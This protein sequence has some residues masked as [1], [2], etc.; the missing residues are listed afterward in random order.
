MKSDKIELSIIVP[1]YN[2]EEYLEECLDSILGQFFSF[3]YEVI[4]VNDGSTDNSKV[5]ANDFCQRYPNIFIYYEQINQGLSVARNSGFSLANGQYIL[6]LDSDD[7]LSNDGLKKLLEIATTKNLDVAIG[8]FI[9]FYENG[10]EDVNKSLVEC[11][12]VTG[13]EW[14][15][16][17]LKKR[18]YMPAVWYKLYRRE[19]LVD[20]DLHFVPQLINEDQLYSVQV[21]AKAK[22]VSAT[23]IPFYRYRHRKG[24]ISK[25][26]DY[27]SALKRVDSDLITTKE[28][29]SISTRLSDARL[30]KMV[31]ERVIRLLKSSYTS[32]AQSEGIEQMELAEYIQK[33]NSLKLYRY[34]RFSRLSHL[35]DFITLVFGF[36]C[37]LKWRSN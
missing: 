16:K 33:A 17:S 6:F 11:D 24:S 3:T 12:V 30:E 13:K 15:Y 32:L 19:F 20:N 34:V 21:F 14:L 7:C 29:I 25:K 26:V 27:R 2:V 36:G 9:H 10:K 37:Y 31:I 1:I 18:K 5:I 23:N 35:V 22:A 28:L 8:N 4:L